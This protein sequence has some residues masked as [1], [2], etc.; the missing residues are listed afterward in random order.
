MSNERPTE[1]LL[2]AEIRSEAGTVVSYARELTFTSIF[3][4]ADWLPPVDTEVDLQLSFPSL[5]DPLQVRAR[6]NDHRITEMLS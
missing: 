6:V 2:R 4:V 5:V 1:I 3:V